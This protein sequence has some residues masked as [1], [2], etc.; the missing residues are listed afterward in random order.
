MTDLNIDGVVFDF[1]GTLINLGGHVEWRKA[2]EEVVQS[3]LDH[4]CA[5]DTVQACNAKGMFTMLDEMYGNLQ[6]ER[7][8]EEARTVQDSI[9]DLIRDYEVRGVDSCVI[10][11]GCT[12]TLDWLSE[13]GVP[14]GV[15]TSNSARSAEEALKLQGLRHHFKVVLGRSVDFPMKPHPAQLLECF[16]LMGVDP[17]RGIMVGDSHKDILAGKAVGSYTVGIPVYFTRLELMK[18]AG[19][20]VIIESLNDLPAVLEGL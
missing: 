16:R 2:Q 3:Y 19:V 6:D 17:A 1:D 13:R 5:E 18:E 12:S 10:M 14:M 9:Y 20:D 15:W 4:D 8:E 7:G 11:D